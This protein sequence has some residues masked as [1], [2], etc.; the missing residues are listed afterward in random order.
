MTSIFNIFSNLDNLK[1]QNND[2]V[3]TYKRENVNRQ[4]PT[5]SLSQG[6]NFNKYQQQIFH[7]YEKDMYRVNTKEGFTSSSSSGSSNSCL[8]QILR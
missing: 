4:I 8:W 5:P 7:K 1:P 2:H 3:R 6:Q